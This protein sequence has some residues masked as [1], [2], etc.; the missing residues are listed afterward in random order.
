MFIE[1]DFNSEIKDAD[2]IITG[3]GRI[4]SQS[5][6]GKAVVGIARRAEGVP[7]IAVV[8][9]ALPG[10]EEAYSQGLTAVFTTNMQPVPF[11][12][13]AKEAHGS[14]EKTVDNIARIIKALK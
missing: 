9:S 1:I 12:Q 5:L 13:A 3:E 7:V 2:L 6:S 11:E 4:D 8:G 14:L 10:Y